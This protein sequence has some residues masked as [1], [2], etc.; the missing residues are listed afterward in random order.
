MRSLSEH[1]LKLL[2][3]FRVRVASES[4][5]HRLSV[6]DLQVL[7]IG[8]TLV[9]LTSRGSELRPQLLG[10]RPAFNRYAC[11]FPIESNPVF[12]FCFRNQL[13]AVVAEL[14]TAGNSKVS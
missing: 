2:Q 10:K 12:V 7:V 13:A 3:P 9:R 14:A 4:L 6:F 8:E 11:L 1:P 5:E